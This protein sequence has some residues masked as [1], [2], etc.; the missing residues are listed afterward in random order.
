MASRAAGS[1]LRGMS[2]PS[3]PS[4][5]GNRLNGR[6]ADHWRPRRWPR[7]IFSCIRQT[8]P[9]RGFPPSARCR[10]RWRTRALPWAASRMRTGDQMSKPERWFSLIVVRVARG[11]T[12]QSPAARSPDAVH[13]PPNGVG[14]PWPR[15]TNK[16]SHVPMV[17]RH[18]H[19]GHRWR[20]DYLLAH[21]ACSFRQSHKA[22][23][24]S[25]RGAVAS[26]NGRPS[27]FYEARLRASEPDHARQALPLQ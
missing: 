16:A 20:R 9:L 10:G 7:L 12:P 24:A 17:C 1:R 3:A 21:L 23:P 6:P 4:G 11:R 5:T 15:S 19:S 27:L 26:K 8:P 14:A 18:V 13:T 25:R 2:T 22:A